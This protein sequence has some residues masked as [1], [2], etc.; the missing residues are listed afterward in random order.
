MPLTATSS[1]AAAETVTDAPD[2]VAPPAGAVR[3][4]DGAVVSAATIATVSS[5]AALEL[6]AASTA[7]TRS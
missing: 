7:T 6:P 2:T 5:D 1:V 3:D 4:T